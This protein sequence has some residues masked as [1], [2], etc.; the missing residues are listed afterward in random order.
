MRVSFNVFLRGLFYEYENN[1]FANYADDATPYT[2]GDNTTEILTNLFSLA[3]N[4]FTGF[5]NNK[6]KANHD[7]C[8]LR[9]STQESSNIQ[10]A[11]FT[12]KSSLNNKISRPHER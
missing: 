6:M 8:H 2:I 9:L 4:L 5:A 12:I 11:N 3:Q 10:I 7:K 1:Y